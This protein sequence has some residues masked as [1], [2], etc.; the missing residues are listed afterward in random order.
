MTE[1]EKQELI[2]SILPPSESRKNIAPDFPYSEEFPALISSDPAKADMFNLATRQLLSN[3]KELNNKKADKATTLAGYGIVDAYTKDEAN[4][5]VTEEI[6]KIVANAPEKFDTLREIA[7]WIDNDETKSA[8]IV[9][10]ITSLQNGKS[11]VGH[12][13]DDRYYTEAEI[14]SKLSGKA[15]SNH[16][17]SQYL[18]GISKDF[19]V[20]ALGYTPSA[21]DTTYN[22]ATQSSTGLMSAS[23]KAKL[24]GIAVNANNYSLPSATSSTLGGVKVG[25]NISVSSGTISISKANVTNALGYTPSASDTTYSAATQSSNGL[26]SASDKAKLDGISS[27]ANNYSLPQATSS[28]LGGVKVGSNITVSSGT[29]SLS[30]ANVTSALG[31]T[32]AT[33]AHTHSQYLTSHNPVDS[34]LSS[35][36]TNAI[37]NK[38]VNAALSGKA[39]SSHTHDDRYYTESEID[40]KLS[41][42]A[43]SSHTHSQYLTSHQ[44]IS[45]KANLSGASFSGSVSIP[46]LTVTSALTIPGG[47]IWIA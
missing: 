43:N 19:V 9:A 12:T 42:K 8:D 2:N 32:P 45:G 21:S 37:Q 29:I 10:N 25:S 15:N 41:G 28:V 4:T 47:K 11:D 31:F 35:T 36:S 44:D 16:T 22:V 30:K 17:H 7:D 14:D 33:E 34:A 20:A 13:H 39:A 38:V 46:T 18:T 3:D 23:D 27:G 5:A 6:A 24:D 26:M 40:S 1:S